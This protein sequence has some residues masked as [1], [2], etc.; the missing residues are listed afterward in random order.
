[1]LVIFTRSLW[2]AAL[3]G[4]LVQAGPPV[5]ADYIVVL[6]GDFT[7]NR[8]LKAGELVR[9]GFARQALVSGPSEMYGVHESDLAIP[10]AVLRG[11]PESYFV[12]VPNDAKSTVA[13]ATVMLAELRRRGAKRVDVVTSDFHTRRAGRIYRSQAGGLDIHIVAAP[14]RYFEPDSWWKSRE[15]QKTFV[16]EWMKTVGSWFGL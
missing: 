14:D 2:L 12:A 1:L 6:A 10:F 13:E 9:E 5:P 16:Y 11:F 7:G 4:Y 8:I 3:G 15:G